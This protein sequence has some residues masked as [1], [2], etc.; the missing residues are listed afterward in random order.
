MCLCSWSER[1]VGRFVLIGD[2]CIDCVVGDDCGVSWDCV[3]E[4]VI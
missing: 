3:C 2:C 1:L 4:Y